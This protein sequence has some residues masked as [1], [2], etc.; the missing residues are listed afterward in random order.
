MICV[1]KAEILENH[2]IEINCSKHNIILGSLYRLPNTSENEFLISMKS[3][4]DNYSKIDKNRK[5]IILGMDHNLDLLK[6]STHVP[7]QKFMELLM[8]K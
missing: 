8:E 6:H 7:T 3:F 2:F 1:L 5:E 4:L